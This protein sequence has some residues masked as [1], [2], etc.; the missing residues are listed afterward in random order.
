MKFLK[1]YKVFESIEAENIV[2]EIAEDVRDILTPL[3]DDGIEIQIDPKF[4]RGV[5]TFIEIFL[6]KNGG[7]HSEKDG[8]KLIPYI[9]E[10]IHLN[11]FLED[12]GWVLKSDPRVSDR[13]WSFD[14]SIDNIKK[15]DSSYSAVPMFYVPYKDSK[16]FI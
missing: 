2:D 8:F 11:S 5:P 12:K 13:N 15:T 6:R 1:N 9:N 14:D 7:M 10:L 3:S 16:N 4:K